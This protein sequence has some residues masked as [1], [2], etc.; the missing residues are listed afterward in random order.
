MANKGLVTVPINLNTTG[1]L[2]KGQ[3]IETSIELSKTAQIDLS[4]NLTN[5]IHLRSNDEAYDI[6]ERELQE[7]RL[8]VEGLLVFRDKSEFPAVGESTSLYIALDE[9]K[10]Y[11]WKDSYIALTIDLSKY[12]TKEEVAQ[13]LLPLDQRI[14]ALEQMHADYYI[15][16][17]GD[18]NTDIH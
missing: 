3:A 7:L 2:D 9:S 11:Y 12:Y 1:V 5:H 14:T 6:L 8:Y 16:D 13:L 15:L 18:A 17:G 4:A 10:L